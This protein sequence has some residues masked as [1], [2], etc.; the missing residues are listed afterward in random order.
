MN[1]QE[2]KIISQSSI[3]LKRKKAHQFIVHGND[4]LFGHASQYCIC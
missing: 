2:C 3:F 1:V 4:T